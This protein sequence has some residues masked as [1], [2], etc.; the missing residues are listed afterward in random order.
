M[1]GQ[2]TWMLSRHVFTVARTNSGSVIIVMRARNWE[3]VT[4]KRRPERLLGPLVQYLGWGEEEGKSFRAKETFSKMWSPDHSGNWEG[5]L[6]IEARNEEWRL[7]Q[8]PDKVGPYVP[9][10]GAG[11]SSWGQWRASKGLYVRTQCLPPICPGTNG[12]KKAK[13]WK[14]KEQPVQNLKH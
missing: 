12:F 5:K 10:W 2:V 13:D 6:G 7:K 8:E 9:C 11:S 14:Q 1:L 3:E 4:A